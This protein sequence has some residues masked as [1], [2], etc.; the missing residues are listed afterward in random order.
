MAVLH[1]PSDSV[2]RTMCASGASKP[3][4]MLHSSK[5]RLSAHTY[6]SDCSNDG[7]SGFCYLPVLSGGDR[8]EMG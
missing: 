5:G 2:P 8:E 7:S 3:L 1:H 4:M 6:L